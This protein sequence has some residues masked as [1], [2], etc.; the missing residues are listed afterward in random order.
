MIPPGASW[1]P[2]SGLNFVETSTSVNGPAGATMMLNSFFV[3]RCTS[4]FLPLGAPAISSTVHCPSTVDQSSTPLVSKSNFTSGALSDTLSSSAANACE[5]PSQ[6]RP[7]TSVAN[8]NWHMPRRVTFMRLPA[9]LRTRPSI[10]LLGHCLPLGAFHER[11]VGDRVPLL[12][13]RHDADNAVSLVLLDRLRGGR[14][15]G[16]LGLRHGFALLLGVCEIVSLGD[17]LR[18]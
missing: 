8:V 3:A 11:H 15:Q 17:R 4:T 7:I 9:Y 10:E 12:H 1:R 13:G 16:P 2:E 6:R 5:E 18:F 14:A